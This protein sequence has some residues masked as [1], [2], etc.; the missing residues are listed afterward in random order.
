MKIYAPIYHK[1]HQK[2]MRSSLWF[3]QKKEVNEA[4]FQM[5]HNKAPEPD[6]FP[7]EFYQIFLKAIKGGFNN[8]FKDFYE[9]KLP[10]FSLNFGI[11]MLLPKQKWQHILSNYV[12]YAY[13]M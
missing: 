2:R 3:L 1:S 5:K 10:L 4:I 11:I 12:L 9:D 7:I 13:S 8:L 6:D